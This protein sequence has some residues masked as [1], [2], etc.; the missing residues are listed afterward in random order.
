M[1]WVAVK[2]PC[3]NAD[4]VI[5][6]TMQMAGRRYLPFRNEVLNFTKLN[7]DTLNLTDLFQDVGPCFTS[8]GYLLPKR[9]HLF[10]QGGAT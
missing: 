2:L 8:S 5:Q 1:N 6:D 9:N 10:G 4:C 7:E 3:P